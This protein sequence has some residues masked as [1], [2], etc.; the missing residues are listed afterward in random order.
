[1]A[2][3][4]KKPDPVRGDKIR[5]STG[6]YAGKVGYFNT[7]M[8]PTRSSVH[9]IIDESQDPCDDQDYLACVRK[10]SLS[11]WK[12]AKT[13]EE[14]AIYEDE[15]VAYH[16]AKLGQALVECGVTGSPTL[17]VLIKEAI[18]SAA[19]VQVSKGNKA[20]FNDL[21]MRMFKSKKRLLAAMDEAME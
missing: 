12:E 10:T 6:T 2:R 19:V 4:T 9:V 18:D 21:A 15:K 3:K 1:M 11:Q 7:A 17:M 8:E 13:H 5:F 16:L 14:M 20:K